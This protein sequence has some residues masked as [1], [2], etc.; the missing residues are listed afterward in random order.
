MIAAHFEPVVQRD[1]LGGAQRGRQRQEARNCCRQNFQFPFVHA[2][3]FM[4]CLFIAKNLTLISK[5]VAPPSILL[6]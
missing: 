6:T 4:L 5:I 1:T 2:C 3:L